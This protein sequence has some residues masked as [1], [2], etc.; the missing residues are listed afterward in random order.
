[1]ASP[2]GQTSGLPSQ[3]SSGPPSQAVRPETTLRDDPF[4]AFAVPG[5][6]PGQR[7]PV[8]SDPFA[9]GQGFVPAD[10]ED[11]SLASN[12]MMLGSGL[13]Q[14]HG[15]EV[16]VDADPCATGGSVAPGADVQMDRGPFIA[17]G[18]DA[19]SLVQEVVSDPFLLNSETR[20]AALARA[21]PPRQDAMVAE[22]PLF[23]HGQGAQEALAAQEAGL[24]KVQEDVMMTTESKA[25]PDPHHKA[26]SLQDL[27]EDAW[28][29]DR[30]YAPSVLIVPERQWSM[31]Q[32]QDL[33]GEGDPKRTDEGLRVLVLVPWVTFLVA[34][35]TLVIVQ[36][37]SGMLAFMLIVFIAG[38]SFFLVLLH[39]LG[40]QSPHFGFITLGCLCLLALFVG[41]LLGQQGWDSYWRQF[42]WTQTGHR[43]MDSVA[44][45]PAAAKVDGSMIHFDPKNN[46]VVDD[47]RSAGYKNGRR[48]CVAPVLTA[49]QISDF[50][51]VQYWAI[52]IDC[53]ENI[54]S[55]SCDDSRLPNGRWGV[56]MLDNGF[57][58][59]GCNA[60]YFREAIVKA[61]N[62]HKLVSAPQALFVRWM[63]DPRHMVAHFLMQALLYLVFTV[64]LS[65]PVFFALGFLAWY[66]GLGKRKGMVPSLSVSFLDLD[67]RQTRRHH[68]N[69]LA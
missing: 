35:L 9:L 13:T 54:G 67:S 20:T 29:T 6:R 59:P 64:I 12:S 8:G 16:Q 38:A 66:G 56:V 19:L 52:G 47:V 36:H 58:C 61:E 42:W 41:V 68:K 39:V 53:C 44:S 37:F 11:V 62:E 69:L 17:R 55:F 1:M 2:S 27:H 33:V 51:I 48:Y 23:M 31:P 5:E 63:K 43:F 22:D 14:V 21:A 32:L 34:V 24:Y 57:P 65:Y 50:T 4:L 26:E 45:T 18:P 49:D 46:S 10:R 40:R 60:E 3:P 7:R 28:L 30:K 15:G 25:E